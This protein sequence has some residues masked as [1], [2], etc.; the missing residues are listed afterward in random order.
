MVLLDAYIRLAADIHR[1]VMEQMNYYQD[2][3][4]LLQE[5]YNNFSDED[6]EWFK[7]EPPIAMHLTLGMHLRNHCGMWLLAW[8]PEMID[9]ADHSPNHPDAISQRAIT[10]FQAKV[11]NAD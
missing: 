7:K 8:V 2:A 6:K 10:D 9:G 3:M 5:I 1:K 11:R 4:D